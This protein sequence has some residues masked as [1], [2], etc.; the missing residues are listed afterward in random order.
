LRE[1]ESSI[2]FSKQ[3]ETRLKILDK[4]VSVKRVSKGHR[5]GRGRGR[6]RIMLSESEALYMSRTGRMLGTGNLIWG[7]IFRF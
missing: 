4:K 1:G 2:F 7:L 3:V 5:N 6:L